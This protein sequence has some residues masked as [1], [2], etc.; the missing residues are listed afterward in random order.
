[1]EKYKYYTIPVVDENNVLHGII[2]VDDVLSQVI[3]IAWR[4]LK[5]IK[6]TPQQAVPR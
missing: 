3:S 1:M 5:K 4:R 6:V 2:T